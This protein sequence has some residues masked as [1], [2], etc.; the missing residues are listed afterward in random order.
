[1]DMKPLGLAGEISIKLMLRKGS[2]TL[3]PSF[4]ILTT[5]EIHL[6]VLKANYVY[7]MNEEK[8]YNI[9]FIYF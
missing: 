5:M 6:S 7:V 1:M 9:I 2:I 4:D 3:C 8:S